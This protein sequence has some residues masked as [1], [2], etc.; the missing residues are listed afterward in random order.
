[1]TDGRMIDAP[2]RELIGVGAS[3]GGNCLPCLRY[4]F[5]EALKAGCTLKEVSEAITLSKMVKERPINDIYHLADE[6]LR[7]EREDNL[8]TTAPVE[9]S[10]IAS[11]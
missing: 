9:G 3:I 11:E 4:H 2:T 10:K 6:L 8:M 7:R 1:M 5:A